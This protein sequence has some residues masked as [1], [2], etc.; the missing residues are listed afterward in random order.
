MVLLMIFNAILHVLLK[1]GKLKKEV[2][3]SSTLQ[4]NTVAKNPM[5]IKDMVVSITTIMNVVA[6]NVAK[7]VL[8][9]V[10]QSYDKSIVG[11]MISCITFGLVTPLIYWFSNKK[12][13]KYAYREFWDGAP[14]C[15]I[16]MKEN[17]EAK[18]GQISIITNIWL[19]E[20]SRGHNRVDVMELQDMTPQ[21]PHQNLSQNEENNDDQSS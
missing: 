14:I 8:F 10:P 18:S 21:T 17:I 19:N 9:Q 6:F 4:F 11:M 16:Q 3:Q 12:L 13:R 20:M 7:H 5:V 1:I 2:E 15:L